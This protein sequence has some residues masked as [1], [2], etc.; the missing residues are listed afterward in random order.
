LSLYS[1]EKKLIDTAFKEAAEIIKN[2]KAASNG[3]IEREIKLSTDEN[4]DKFFRAYLEKNTNDAVYSEE[5]LGNLPKTGKVWIVDPLDGS[6]NFF[7]NIPF[8]TSSIALWE[9]G[10][11]L[12]GFVYDYVHDEYYYGEIGHG[13][14]LNDKLLGKT[15]SQGST[16]KMTGI[17]SHTKVEDSLKMFE[18]SLQSYKKLRWM[19]CASLSLCYVAAG[20]ADAYEEQ[21]IKLWD[22][23]AGMAIVMA[24]GGHVKYDHNADGSLNLTAIHGK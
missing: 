18:A 15:E 23:A 19:G 14:F 12:L 9:N 16:I 5:S 11:P 13:A 20:R 10:A 4:L 1:K 2:S 7:K 3:F 24:A 8:Y 17:P 6:L 22:V 21:G